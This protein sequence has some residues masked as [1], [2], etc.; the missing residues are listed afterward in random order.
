MAK[1][2]RPRK[3]ASAALTH[4][5]HLRVTAEELA[6]ITAAV[7]DSIGVTVRAKVVDPGSLERSTGK[8]RR[9]IDGRS[10]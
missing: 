5:I 3:D 8:M 9:V 10:K 7:K 6:K 4:P 1:R 2:G